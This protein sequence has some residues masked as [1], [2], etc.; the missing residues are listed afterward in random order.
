MPS[1]EHEQI[2]NMLL[3]NASA[4]T[5]P[6]AQQRLNMEAVA[7]MFPLPDDVEIEA[8]DCDGVVADWISLADSDPARVVMYLHGGAYTKGSRNTHREL[9][10]RIARASRARVLVPEYRLAPEHPCPAGIEDAMTCWR[11][12][13]A[14][15]HSVD[16]L[17]IA[18]DS[19]GAGLALALMQSAK[20]QG[21]PM[22]ARAA[23]IAPWVDLELVGASAKP[24][25]VDDPML[26]RDRLLVDAHHYAGEDLR[27]WQASP[28]HGDL[29]D[30]PPMLIQVGGRDLLLSD[31]TRLAERA[32]TAGNDVTLEVEDG[33]VHVW[34]FFPMLPESHSAI[35]R[36]GT[37]LSGG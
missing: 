37:F 23:L 4:E 29:D 3:A 15:G 21:L 2:V 6:I 31:S 22:P 25:A 24:G 32:Q 28:L 18:G 11:W 34:H 10:S 19:A 12:L 9:A 36:L 14:Q 27:R 33:L 7:E 5:L 1:P 17:T 30:L 20:S 8:I 16:Q 13:I 35:A 26:Q